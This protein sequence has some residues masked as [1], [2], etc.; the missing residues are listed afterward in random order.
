MR[1]V[2]L[3]LT[4]SHWYVADVVSVQTSD[5]FQD[6]MIRI[7]EDTITFTAKVCSAGRMYSSWS[8]SSKQPT[9]TDREW[10]TMREQ[11]EALKLSPKAQVYSTQWLFQR[12]GSRIVRQKQKEIA[13]PPMRRLGESQGQQARRFSAAVTRSI[14]RGGR[15]WKILC[16]RGTR[17]RATSA[18]GC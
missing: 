8:L 2:L 13:E 7:T 15:L 14:V 18:D 12:S 3:N 6:I 4:N 9:V 16:C 1:V 10:Q 11:V 5:F 17:S